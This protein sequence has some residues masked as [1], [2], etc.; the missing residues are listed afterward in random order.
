MLSWSSEW[1]K[2]PFVMP[3]DEKVYHIRALA[4][5]KEREEFVKNLSRSV[6]EKTTFASRAA[7]SFGSER[8]RKVCVWWKSQEFFNSCNVFYHD[9]VSVFLNYVHCS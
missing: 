7:A 9:V 3:P 4:K 1:A 6:T 8:L 2:K 5:K